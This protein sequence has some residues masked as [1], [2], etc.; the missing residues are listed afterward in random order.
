MD[1]SVT[2]K[3]QKPPFAQPIGQPSEGHSI[4]ESLNQWI[5]H[6]SKL[7]LVSYYNHQ[8][9]G[10]DFEHWAQLVRSQ[11]VTTL[12]RRVRSRKR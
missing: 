9:D 1:S 6:L 5:E 12:R 10:F 7:S 3:R 8:L 11:L 4:E 2:P